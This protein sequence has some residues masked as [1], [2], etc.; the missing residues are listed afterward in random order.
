MKRRSVEGL[1]Q[2]PQA[3][4]LIDP[5]PRGFQRNGDFATIDPQWCALL[6][7]PRLRRVTKQVSDAAI[8]I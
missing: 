1:F 2:H 3:L 8:P 6:G 4:A 7:L 5:G